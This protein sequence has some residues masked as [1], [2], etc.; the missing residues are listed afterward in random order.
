LEGHGSYEVEQRGAN[1]GSVF[2]IVSERK[3]N[4]E[5]EGA[6]LPQWSVTASVHIQ[7][8]RSIADGVNCVDFH[9]GGDRGK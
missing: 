2:A 8:G 7:G 3:A 4:Q 1:A 5:G 6:G 9:Y